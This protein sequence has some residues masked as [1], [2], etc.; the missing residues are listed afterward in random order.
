MTRLH[1]AL[2]LVA[3]LAFSVACDDEVITADLVETAPPAAE[4][5]PSDEP[6]GDA[7]DEKAADATEES[8]EATPPEV[9]PKHPELGKLAPEFKLKDLDGT[10]HAISSFRGKIVVIEWI[11]HGCPFVKKHYKAG[12]MQALQKQ[13]KDKDVVWLSICS[14]AEGKQGHMSA[15]DW[16]KTQAEKKAMPTAVL[17]D[18]PGDVG[19]QY[20]VKKTPTM[21]VLDAEGRVAYMGAIDDNARAKGADI[22]KAKNY[23]MAAVDALKAGKTPEVTSTDAYG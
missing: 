5:S 22:A 16:K 18:T 9:A 2:A 12:N 1:S 14:S 6:A 21:F 13:A 10:E 15:E 17:L 3:V 8:E 4:M 19:R 20:Q 11:N 23:V 7:A